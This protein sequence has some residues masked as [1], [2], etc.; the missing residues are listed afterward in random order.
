[1]PGEPFVFVHLLPEK[2]VGEGDTWSGKLPKVLAFLGRKVQTVHAGSFSERFIDV[3]RYDKQLCARI[4]IQLQASINKMGFGKP[5]ELKLEGSL[6]FDLDRRLPIASDW[7]GTYQTT[8]EFTVTKYKRGK[9]YPVKVSKDFDGK[10][11]IQ[12]VLK[13]R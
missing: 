2:P 8:Q 3:T 7:E 12:H 13:P 4:K 1:M 10:I 6:Y 5:L 9:P 11:W